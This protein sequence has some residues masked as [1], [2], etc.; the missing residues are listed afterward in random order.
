MSILKIQWEHIWY[1]CLQLINSWGWQDYGEHWGVGATSSRTH[2]QR[3]RWETVS[4]E[5]RAEGIR[6]PQAVSILSL[7]TMCISCG[8][9]HI[10]FLHQMVGIGLISVPR[11]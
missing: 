9:T 10:L 11:T 8:P 6:H 7:S 2:Q 3:A 1:W 4:R 5:I